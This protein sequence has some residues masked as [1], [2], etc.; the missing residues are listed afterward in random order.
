MHPQARP[1]TTRE[2]RSLLINLTWALLEVLGGS[3]LP[4]EYQT[5]MGQAVSEN[6]PAAFDFPDLDLCLY[7]NGVILSG[8]QS[9][10]AHPRLLKATY[11]EQQ[12]PL[13]T[14]AQMLADAAERGFS[15]YE[16]FDDCEVGNFFSYWREGTPTLVA[17]Q[18]L[19]DDAWTSRD[20]PV[21][22]RRLEG[23][24]REHLKTFRS[25]RPGFVLPQRYGDLPMLTTA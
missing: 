9:L 10:A 11:A 3:D 8:R 25:M 22:A 15:V 21:G 12:R 4:D 24:M 19:Q 23:Q 2:A 14:T 17:Y 7:V 13:L 20:F 5:V 16:G 1:Y 6:K 18:R